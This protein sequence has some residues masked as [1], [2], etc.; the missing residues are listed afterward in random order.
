[1]LYFPRT[2]SRSP[3]ITRAVAAC[4]LEAS[5]SGLAQH[6]I[7]SLFGVNQGQV[8]KIINGKWW[9]KK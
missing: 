4:I 1:M 9:P 3:R 6:H 2:K 8:S 5:K 7:A